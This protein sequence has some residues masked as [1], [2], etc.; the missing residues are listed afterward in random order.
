[1]TAEREVAGSI[2]GAGPIL[3][4]LK[5]LRNE[6][7]AFALQTAGP[8]RGSDDHV[9]AVPS[10]LGDV[11]IVPPITTFVL[12]TLTLKKKCVFFSM[13]KLARE[14]KGHFLLNEH[15]DPS[16]FLHNFDEIIIFFELNV[17]L[18]KSSSGK[19]VIEKNMYKIAIRRC[20]VLKLRSSTRG[21]F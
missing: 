21:T 14:T 8:S 13:T 12:N 11:K 17:F 19:N 2:P 7:T 5:Y 18:K 1:M 9:E 10:P 4:V 3:R 15:S 20:K 6:G 16:F